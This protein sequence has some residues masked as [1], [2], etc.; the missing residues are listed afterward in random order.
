MKKYLFAMLFGAMVCS[1]S[2]SQTLGGYFY[3]NDS[4]PSGWEWQSPDSLG[5]NKLQPHA[6]FF[7]F[8]DVETAVRVLPANSEYVKDLNGKWSFHWAKQPSERLRDF[9]NTDF[10]DSSWEKEWVPMCWN[11][12]GRQKDGTWK[13]GRPIYSNQRV[14]FQHRVA[15]DDWKGG[16]MRP[17]P[18]DWL[19]SEFPNEVGSYR[20]TFSIPKHWDGREVYI[21]FDGV[22]SFFY[23]WINGRYVGFSKNSRSLAEF[24]ITP[25]LNRGEDNVVAVEVYRNSDGSFLESQDMFRL[26]GIIRS[27]YLTAKPKVQVSDIVAIPSYKDKYFTNA[28][29]NITATVQNL[30][31][32]R[33]AV[34]VRYSLYEVTLYGDITKLL[35]DVSAETPLAVAEAGKTLTLKT[36]LQAG[37]AVRPWTAEQPQR[38]VLVGEMLDK[39]GRVLETFSTYTG[40]R[41][42]EIRQVS[43]AEDEFGK[44]GRYYLLNG[45]PIKMK[46]VNRHETNPISGHHID[47]YQMEDEVLLMKRGNIN[48]VRNSHYPTDPMWYYFCDKYG[49]MLEDEANIESHEYYYGRESLSHAPAFRNMHVARNMEMVHAHVNHPSILIWSLGNEAGPGDNF[50]AAYDSIKAF[51]TSRPVQYERDTE[52]KIVDFYSNQ[53]PSVGFVQ[54]A[55]QGTVNIKYP[56]HISEYA[57]SMGNAVGN[58]IDYWQAIESSNY[59]MGGAIW[60]WVDQAI[61]AVKEDRY[62]TPRERERINNG[63][64]RRYYYGYGGDFRDKPNDGMFCMNGILRPDRS[65]KAQYYE[66]KKVYQNVGVSLVDTATATIEIFNKNYFNDLSDYCVY[67]NLWK[68]GEVVKGAKANTVDDALN[69]YS[70]GKYY[71]TLYDVIDHGRLA[72][73]QNR[74]E[75]EGAEKIGPRQRKQFRLDIDTKSL[76][77]TAE[78]FI[79]VQF[80]LAKDMPWSKEGYVQMEEQLLLQEPAPKTENAVAA[81]DN[82]IRCET[83]DDMFT[84]VGKDFSVGFSKKTGALVSLVRGEKEMIAGEEGLVLD[85]FRAPTDN[86]NWAMNAWVQAGLDRLKH[87]ATASETASLP[88]G[89]HFVRFTIESQAEHPARLVYSN[90]DRNPEDVY[91]VVE[92]TSKPQDFKLTSH[93]VYTIFPNGRIELQSAITSNNAALEMPRLGYSVKLDKSLEE[94]T[95]YGRGPVNNYNDRKTGQFVEIHSQRVGRDIMLPKPQAMGNREDV[96]WLS[97]TDKSDAGLRFTPTSNSTLEAGTGSPVTFS[98]SALPYTQQELMLAA[99]PYQLPDSKVTVLHLDAKVTGLGGNSCGQGGPLNRDRVRATG[100]LFGFNITA[101]DIKKNDFI[102]KQDVSHPILA[103]RDRVGTVTLQTE[104]KGTVVYSINNGKEQVYGGPFNFREGGKLKVRILSKRG[105]TPTADQLFDYDYEFDEIPKTV[106][107]EVVYT[108]SF[109]PGEGEGSHLVDG[110]MNT[111]WHTQYGVTLA[112]YPHWVDFDAA[113][114]QTMKGFVYT[115]RTDSPNGYVKDYEIYVSED[116]NS[117]TKIHSGTFARDGRPQKIIFQKPVRARYIRFY[118]LNEQGGAEYASGAEF[119]LITE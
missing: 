42:A 3:G 26:P 82:S 48:H 38:Y 95:Y 13:Y 115:P 43:A 71:R 55:C 49:I 31:K 33:A 25:Y 73:T 6:W 109:E 86:D 98:A 104:A 112:K 119:S 9:Y 78:Y 81:K 10:D 35:E 69:S 17:A 22:D 79:E 80:C 105:E 74:L 91:K 37:V 77:P 23:L 113:Q 41:Q 16:V 117:W 84:Y 68:N 67:W 90:R 57:H 106:P 14:I 116:N 65:A 62:I 66:V 36:E 18:K 15:V 20:R 12:A 56:M 29:L 107:L 1:V 103:S 30:T 24:C 44:A 93:V 52:S 11:T 7:N 72:I 63:Y 89:R 108:S 50:K 2:Y 59:C 102:A 101:N 47:R 96:R 97:L 85:P 64:S 110:K 88:D 4:Q 45:K 60:D 27:V 75:V 70:N 46:G 51:D 94:F 32:K 21:N 58:L 61:Y 92:D 99:H 54:Q 19:V 34:K 8:A 39:K 100:V 5:Y 83:S 118:A 111:I 114:M 76:D 53:Y 87:K 40:F 28:V